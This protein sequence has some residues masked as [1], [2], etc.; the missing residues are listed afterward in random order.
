MELSDETV[1]KYNV[2]KTINK[3]KNTLGICES[4][5]FV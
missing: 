4:R 3:V 1:F 5:N 2:R